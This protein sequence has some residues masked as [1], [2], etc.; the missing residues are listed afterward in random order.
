VSTIIEYFSTP[1]GPYEFRD[2]LIKNFRA[3]IME[4]LMKTPINGK[5]RVLRE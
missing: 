5:R 4:S 1:M 3:F 2:R